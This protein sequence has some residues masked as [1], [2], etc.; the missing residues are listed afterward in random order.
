MITWRDWLLPAFL[1]MVGN[2]DYEVSHDMNNREVRISS[3][4][5]AFKA[6]GNPEFPFIN[7]LRLAARVAME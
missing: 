4:L 1:G 7:D 6:Y 2:H 3:A 5:G